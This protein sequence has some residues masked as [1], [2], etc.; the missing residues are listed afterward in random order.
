MRLWLELGSAPWTTRYAPLAV[1]AAIYRE[2]RLLE[3]LRQVAVG[4]KTVRYSPADKLTQIFVSMLAGCRTLA[5]LNTRLAPERALAQA[6]GW[7]AWADQSTL[8][9]TLDGLSQ[10]NL[11]QLRAA[12]HQISQRVAASRY[13]DWRALLR[14]ELDLSGLPASKRAEASARGYF[15]GKKTPQDANSCASVHFSITRRS[16]PSWWRA[17]SPAPLVSPWRCATSKVRLT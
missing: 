17:T 10:S 12:T 9:R 4:T 6:W 5:E 8:Q 7:P 2:W 16:G 3:P 15:S 1:L 14:L 13:H 11:A